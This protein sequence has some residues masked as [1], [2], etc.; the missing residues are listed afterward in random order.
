MILKACIEK[1]LCEK[2]IDVGLFSAFL[3]RTHFPHST[4]HHNFRML[5]A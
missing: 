1:S 2:A 4:T 3:P 5:A